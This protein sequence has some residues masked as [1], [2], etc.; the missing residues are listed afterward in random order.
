MLN[1][2]ESLQLGGNRERFFRML[3]DKTFF[4]RKYKD[5]RLQT[6]EVLEHEVIGEVVKVTV[7]LSL[8][9]I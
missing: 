2:D 6:A 7:R 1:F 4:E 3:Q 9:H 8:I 5:M